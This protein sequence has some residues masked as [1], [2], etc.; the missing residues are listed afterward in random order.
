MQALPS[1]CCR[2]C[3]PAC[4]RLLLPQI[5]LRELL[6]RLD[7]DQDGYL[8]ALDLRRLVNTVQPRVT[9]AQATYIKVRGRGHAGTGYLH[10]GEGAGSRNLHQGGGAG[11]R[12]HRLPTSR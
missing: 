2:Y 9:Q 5:P 3:P 7:S 1:Y 4:S 10:Q 12:R 6:R 11:S 8:D